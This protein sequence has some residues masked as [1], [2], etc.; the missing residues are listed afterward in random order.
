[1]KFYSAL[2]AFVVLVA[3]VA[4]SQAEDMKTMCTND[5]NMLASELK[6]IVGNTQKRQAFV[7]KLKAKVQQECTP[8]NSCND[9]CATAINACLDK[10]RASSTVISNPAGCCSSC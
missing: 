8:K 4:F 2:L 5:A 9:A 6:P 1:M 3:V 7:D 10:Q